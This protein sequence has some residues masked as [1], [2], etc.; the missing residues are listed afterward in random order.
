M[1]HSIVIIDDEPWIAIDLKE[2][3]NWKDLGYKILN[4]LYDP[5]MALK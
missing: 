4:A 1:A 2:N 3:I 5:S